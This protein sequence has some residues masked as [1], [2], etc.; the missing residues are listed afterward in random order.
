MPRDYY[1]ILGVTRTAEADEIKK[2][3]RKLAKRYHPDRNKAADAAAK[4]REAQEAYD[5]ISD[6]EKRKLYDQ[7]GHA[8]VGVGRGPGGAGPGQGFDPFGSQGRT[9]TNTGPGGFSFR[10]DPGAEG[11]D[12]GDIF[13][14]FFGGGGAAGTRRPGAGRTQGRNPFGG[15]AASGTPGEDLHHAVTISFEQS[16]NGGT[17][18]LQLSNGTA[19]Q[20]IDVK[21][22]RGVADG[23]KLRIGGKGHPSPTGGPSGDLL[24]KI[25]VT[26]HE[27]FHREGLDLL[28]D[29]PV[30]VDEAIFGAVVDVPTL[31]GK[32]S[33]KVPPL[34]SGG[35]KLRVR[36]A[37]IET[38]K[39]EKGDLYAVIRIDVPKELTEEQTK[40]FEQLRGKLPNPRS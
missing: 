24:L 32:V 34:S 35:R 27:K 12:V 20:T 19:T 40:I 17:I 29:V 38:S 8:G 2:A 13:S 7:F 9:T 5:V 18:P 4:F 23:A 21:I 39:G 26:P 10:V 33:M 25:R 3:Y 31:T 6:P 16:V 11:V 1:D 30:S 28:V 36:G 22:P 14:Q 15:G 37:G